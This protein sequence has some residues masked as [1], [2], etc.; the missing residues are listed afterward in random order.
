[1]NTPILTIALWSTADASRKYPSTGAS[2]ICPR[3]V[4]HRGEHDAKSFIFNYIN[5]MHLAITRTRSVDLA[6]PT[7][8]PQN[9]WVSLVCLGFQRRHE[10]MPGEL[11]HRRSKAQYKCTSKKLFVK[12]LA[13]IK[14]REARMQ[15]IIFHFSF[16]LILRCFTYFV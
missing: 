10:I 9:Q 1:V 2:T 5:N 11:E 14:C 15:A 13:R 8:I 6:Q 3:L 12:Q 16:T 7:H 4:T